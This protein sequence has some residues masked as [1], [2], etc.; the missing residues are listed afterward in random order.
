MTE[1]DMAIIRQDTISLTALVDGHTCEPPPGPNAL[2]NAGGP[3]SRD[4]HSSF[5]PPPSAS[6]I[7]SLALSSA[8]P[9]GLISSV[10]SAIMGIVRELKE[11]SALNK[12]LSLSTEQLLKI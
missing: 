4:H 7:D 5:T 9:F 6:G 12:F 10:R 3:S 8:S 1:A 11:L 2:P